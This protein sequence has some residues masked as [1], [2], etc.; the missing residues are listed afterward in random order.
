MRPVVQGREEVGIT[1]A[2]VTEQCSSGSRTSSKVSGWVSE[3]FQP[4]LL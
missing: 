1:A 2:S 3:A 4:S